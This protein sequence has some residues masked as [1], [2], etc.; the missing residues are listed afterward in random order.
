MQFFY[1]H[2]VNLIA[3]SLL[4]CA[5]Y[6]ARALGGITEKAFVKGTLEHIGDI[7]FAGRFLLDNQDSYR[8]WFT[9]F[10]WQV[11]QNHLSSFLALHDLPKIW[12][13]NELAQWG[14]PEHLPII[15]AVLSVTHGIPRSKLPQGHVFFKVLASMNVTESN[16]KKA[17]M[18][19]KEID[20]ESEIILKRVEYILDVIVT[21]MSIKRAEEMGFSYKK[22]DAT[23]WLINPP[24]LIKPTYDYKAEVNFILS[25]ER[26]FHNYLLAHSNQFRLRHPL[27]SGL[28]IRKHFGNYRR[29]NK[30]KRSCR[31]YLEYPD[32]ARGDM[33]AAN[34]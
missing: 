32:L 13:R 31:S 25:F 10:E 12:N 30:I 22:Y 14:Y 23:E 6:R 26:D 7:Q 29:K 18:K 9:V 8:D 27:S 24:I 3:I 16:Y 4:V 33:A 1:Y 34:E 11:L 5:P 21:K 2:S 20:R 17:W 15:K 19:H 28:N